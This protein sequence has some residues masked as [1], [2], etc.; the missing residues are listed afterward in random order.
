MEILLLL[1][2]QYARV[3]LQLPQN[4]M[5]SIKQTILK[6]IFLFFLYTFGNSGYSL[7]TCFVPLVYVSEQ[8]GELSM[9][10]ITRIQRS[11]WLREGC[12]HRPAAG[13]ASSCSHTHTGTHAKVFASL[14][15]RLS[16][17]FRKPSSPICQPM[18]GP[19]ITTVTTKETTHKRA[20]E[21]NSSCF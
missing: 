3:C 13:N 9:R 1:F 15:W 19:Q 5:P 6:A 16:M 7:R 10:L 8:T 18:L 17:C 11:I 12:T 20:G 21:K 2:F 14:R 4:K